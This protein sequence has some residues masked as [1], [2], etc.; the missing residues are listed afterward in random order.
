M[1]CG[2]PIYFALQWYAQHHQTEQPWC[3]AI[4]ESIKRDVILSG[5][6]DTSFNFRKPVF[7]WW[8]LPDIFANTLEPLADEHKLCTGL[9]IQSGV[10]L[11]GSGLEGKC[12]ALKAY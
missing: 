12:I 8:M 2:G 3:E 11:E 4:Q 5:S 9:A 7:I 1:A 10:S 6:F